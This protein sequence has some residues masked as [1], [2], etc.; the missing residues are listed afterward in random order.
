MYSGHRSSRRRFLRQAA[1]V[2]VL[3]LVLA[4]PFARAGEPEVLLDVEPSATQ[5]PYAPAD[6]KVVQITPPPFIWVPVKKAGA[7]V[8]QVSTSSGLPP[9]GIT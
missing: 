4:R 1:T 9:R 6:G 5:K 2:V 7:Y 3:G 8:L